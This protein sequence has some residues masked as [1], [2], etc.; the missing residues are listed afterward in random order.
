MRNPFQFGDIVGGDTFCNRVQ[1]K[2]EIK[3][4]IQNNQKLFIYSERRLGKTSLISEVIAGLPKSKWIP[5][6]VDLYPTDG[7]FTFAKAMAEAIANSTSSTIDQFLKNAKRL[8]NQLRLSASVDMMGNPTFKLESHGADLSEAELQEVLEAPAKLAESS[9]KG[10]LVVFDEFQQVSEYGNDF[11]ERKIR[12]VI[13]S[14]DRVSYIFMGSKRHLIKKMFLEKSSPLYRSAKQ[15]ALTPISLSD[16][17]PFI[18]EKFSVTGRSI[19]QAMIEIIVSKTEGHP[20]YTQ[21]LCYELWEVS[22]PD[23]S[24]D[25]PLIE[26]AVQQLL[27][28]EGTAFTTLWETCTTNQR[29]ILKALAAEERGIQLYSAR[30]TKEHRLGSPSSIRR[31]LDSLVEKDIV[32]TQD[33]DAYITDRFFRLWIEKHMG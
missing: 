28:H 21:H 17:V 4:H 1:E 31:S 6:Y 15:Y 30:M 22:A 23:A 5:I 2:R 16:W 8:F 19:D 9:R 7:E 13:Q 3:A 32:D 20:F 33:G 12:S 25:E 26:E 27:V 18:I 11:V 10:V 14:H 24:V 29:R